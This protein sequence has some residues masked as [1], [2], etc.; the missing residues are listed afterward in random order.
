MPRIPL[1]NSLRGAPTRAERH[2]VDVDAD[3]LHEKQAIE[4]LLSSTV[5]LSWQSWAHAPCGLAG[6]PRAAACCPTG[7]WY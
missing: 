4:E 7:Q 3:D 1:R 5:R 2:A 6:S